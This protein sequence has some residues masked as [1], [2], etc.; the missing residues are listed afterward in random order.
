MATPSANGRAIVEISLTQ[1]PKELRLTVAHEL[2]ARWR[3]RGMDYALFLL[4]AETPVENP[5][6]RVS[7]EKIE[8]VLNGLR[9]KGALP[10]ELKIPP[11]LT[12]P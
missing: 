6:I 2:A 10:D 3:L 11:I 7:A 8:L 5:H 4:A 12:A 9:P 1:I